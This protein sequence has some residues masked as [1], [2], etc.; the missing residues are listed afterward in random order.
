M[1]ARQTYLAAALVGLALFVAA[2]L[3]SGLARLID[4]PEERADRGPPDTAP[5]E[6]AP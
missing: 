1:A 2:L 5:A 6:A 4:P 3:L